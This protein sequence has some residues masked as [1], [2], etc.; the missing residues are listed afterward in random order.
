MNLEVMDIFI[1][2]DNDPETGFLSWQWPV[3][4]GADYLFEGNTTG[5]SV[6][7][8]SDPDHGWGWTEVNSFANVCN[9]SSIK[10]VNDRKAIEF[11]IDKTKIG[12]PVGYV[13][14]GMTE[15]DGTWSAIVLLCLPMNRQPHHFFLLN[16]K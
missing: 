14:F 13:T 15:M 5:G 4:S 7:Q 6:Y 2:A 16:Y 3:S 8:H 12:N 10:V 1:N 11:S 9:F